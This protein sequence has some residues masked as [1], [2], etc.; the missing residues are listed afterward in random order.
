MAAYLTWGLYPQMMALRTQGDMTA[1]DA[2]HQT[3]SRWF[4]AQALLL[5]QA[6][7][8]DD[9]GFDELVEERVDVF[10]HFARALRVE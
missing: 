3:Y 8:T 5:L 4:Q 2:L 10:S 1:F 7:Q 9:V 6:P